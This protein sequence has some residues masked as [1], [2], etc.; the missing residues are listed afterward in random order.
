MSL[1][2]WLQFKLNRLV[3]IFYNHPTQCL[4]NTPSRAACTSAW[5]RCLQGW[6]SFPR[7]LFMGVVWTSC[8]TRWA[9]LLAIELCKLVTFT[10]L[11]NELGSLSGSLYANWFKCIMHST[12]L[13]YFWVRGYG[14]HVWSR[15]D[16][17]VQISRWIWLSYQTSKKF[18]IEETINKSRL[19]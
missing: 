5:V 4:E 8:F 14:K 1:Q 11:L 17:E 10:T 12:S 13:S 16:I 2:S 7:P 15:W 18:L 9:W 3:F 19:Q 6:R